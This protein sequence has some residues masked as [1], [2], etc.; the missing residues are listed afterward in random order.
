MTVMTPV[1]PM[2][3]RI[4]K[5]THQPIF[6]GQPWDER[7]LAI[8]VGLC[9][10][11][12][13]EVLQSANGAATST[14]AR[15]DTNASF[16][17]PQKTPCGTMISHATSATPGFLGQSGSDQDGTAALPG[18]ATPAPAPASASAA[19]RTETVTETV[20]VPEPKLLLTVEDAAA[21]LSVGRPK[22]WQLV[23]QRE[24]LSLKIG[25]S[26][27]VPVAALDDYVQR[28]S[29]AEQAAQAGR[30]SRIQR[31]EGSERD[32]RGETYG[33]EK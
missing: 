19:A 26:R 8:L 12:C 9:V 23:M 28:L 10:A 25:A 32:E 24:V 31:V 5:T 20:R 2:T 3:Q 13:R 1:T 4:P 15:A 21:R 14:S 11:A 16:K 6:S 33:N 7:Q 27:R 18:T 29:V 22:M 30:T 17:T